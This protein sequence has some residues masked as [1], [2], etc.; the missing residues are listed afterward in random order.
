[1]PFRISVSVFLSVCLLSANAAAYTPVKLTRSN[2]VKAAVDAALR[3]DWQKAGELAQKTADKKVVKLVEWL[4]L[5]RAADGGA[6]FEDMERFMKKNAHFPRIY[7]IRR[8]AEKALM[9]QGD[10]AALAKWFKKHPPVA[11]A[12]VIKQAELLMAKKEWE[13]A[14]PMLYQLWA[15]GELSDDETQAVKEKLSLL[16]D[17]HD[18]ANRVEALL[19]ERK[20][21]QAQKLLPELGDESRRL[22]VVRIGLINNDAHAM[23]KIKSLPE[24]MQKNTGLLFDELRWLRNKSKYDDA[25]NLLKSVPMAVQRGD[26]W[27][28]ERVTVA[29]QL[30]NDGQVR[31]AYDLVKTHSLPKG[32]SYADAEWMAGW[33]ALRDLKRSALA[34]KHFSNMLSAVKSPVSLARGEYWMGRAFEASKNKTESRRWYR[35]AARRITTIY[36]QLAAGRLKKDALPALPLENAPTLNEMDGIRKNELFQMAKLLQ[37]AGQNELTDVFAARLVADAKTPEQTT[38]LAYALAEDLQRPDLAVNI[39][40]RARANGTYIVSLGYPV[41]DLKHDERAEQALVLSI[42]RQESNF[43]T[44]AVSPAGARGLMQILPSTAKQIARRKK[45]KFSAQMLNSNPDFNVEMGSAYFADMLK[46]FDGSYILAVAAYNAGPT[47]VRKW[48]KTMGKPDERLDAIDWIERIPFGETRNY[49][50]RVLENLHIYR[51]NLNYPE[52]ELD[53]WRQAQKSGKN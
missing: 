51:R 10:D 18:F 32:G 19:D 3:D 46:R 42:I 52:T 22:A 45:K 15:K 26:K 29:R 7:V 41:W 2:D 9:E 34:R 43:S 11:P 8:N 28:N 33:I 20:P 30:L 5:T 1:M 14:V 17:E 47:N 24:K 6:A 38:A 21:K 44:D 53:S 13:R 12:A 35:M 48:M 49:V 39:A 23:R 27:W 31:A 36:G 40:R 16:L 25:V 37:Q 4:R 50:Q